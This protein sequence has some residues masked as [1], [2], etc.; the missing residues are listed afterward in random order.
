MGR[1]FSFP[2]YIMNFNVVLVGCGGTGGCFFSKFIRFMADTNIPNVEIN[3]SIIDGDHVESKNI[4]RQPF[5]PEDVGC[6]KAIALA[7]AAEETLGVHVKAYP[8]YVSDQNYDR[9]LNDL[10]NGTFSNYISVLIG[11]VDN[12]ACRKVLHRVFQHNSW[13]TMFYIDSANEFSSGDVVFG[14]TSDYETKAPDRCHYYPEILTDSGKP[15]Y[16]KSCEELN[17][18]EPQHLA[19]N[20]LASDLIFSYVTQLITHYEAATEAPGGIAYFDALNFFSRF[21]AYEEAR[22]GKIK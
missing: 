19:T 10:Y 16:E 14:K 4:G 9:L 15:V 12:H 1:E 7:T 13:N 6:N 2:F 5:V 22:H 20:S 3:F 11:A 18:S 17:I 21:D 8:E